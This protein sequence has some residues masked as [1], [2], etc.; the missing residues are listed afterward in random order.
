MFQEV[1]GT[2]GS[3]PEILSNSDLDEDR[4]RYFVQI[5][6]QSEKSFYYLL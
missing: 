1:S 6:D 3:N 5:L 4:G 2:E